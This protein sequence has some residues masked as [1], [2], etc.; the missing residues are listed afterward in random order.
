MLAQIIP[1][2]KLVDL[3]PETDACQYLPVPTV[4]AVAGRPIL[5]HTM[6]FPETGIVATPVEAFMIA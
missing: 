1:I 5:A 4:N 3:V 2:E 6:Y